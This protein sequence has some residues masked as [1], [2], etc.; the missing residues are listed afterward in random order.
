MGM[1]TGKWRG[2][3]YVF[4]GLYSNEAA[5]AINFII[6][7]ASMVGA[8]RDIRHGGYAQRYYDGEVIVMAI[9]NGYAAAIRENL[10]NEAAEL[11]RDPV[12]WL[13]CKPR[14]GNWDD[15]VDVAKILLERDVP[16]NRQ[17]S[18][19]S[20]PLNPLLAARIETMLNECDGQAD[21]M[22]WHEHDCIDVAYRM[23]VKAAADGNKHL[24]Q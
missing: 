1:R 9:Y 19:V 14:P 5:E 20:H 13:R 4:T 22:D 21:L 8:I 2:N 11:L 23:I 6:D 24:K 15:V 3:A 12:D 18:L 10:L 17:A 7:I 16:R